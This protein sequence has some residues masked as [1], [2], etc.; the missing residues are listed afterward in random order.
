MTFKK[1]VAGAS[2]KPRAAF[3]WISEVNKASSYQDLED[4]GDFENL[5]AKIA[6]G[7]TEILHGEFQ[8]RVNVLEENAASQGKMLSGRSIAWLIYK[9]MKV[10]ETEGALLEFE[11][12]LKVELKGDNLL[13]LKNNWD[14]VLA[15]LKTRPSDDVLES[16]FR[17]QLQRSQQLKETMALYNQ[18]IV[19]KGVKRSY[20]KLESMLNSYLNNKR[21][22]QNRG[23]LSHD[24]R[25]LGLNA[26]ENP[27]SGDCRQWIK[28]GKCSG[29]AY[30]WN[31]DPRK[32]GAKGRS[33][34]RGRGRGKG[35]GRSKSRKSIFEQTKG[36]D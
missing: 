13:G 8:R 15:S 21:L 33:K 11:D 30:P 29:D 19:Q 16:L 31:H 3:Q 5:A 34:S 1:K 25:R 18:D 32:K 24:H 35:G 17:R 14:F 10:S 23:A 9:E 12:L 2:R 27:T 20:K 22:Q 6:S 4:P 28:S 36:Q 7:L 26:T